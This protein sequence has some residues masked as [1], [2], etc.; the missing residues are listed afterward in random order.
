MRFRRRPAT[1]VTL[2][3]ARELRGAPTPA[4][5]CA[6]Q[7]LR[8]RRTLG[9]K[10]RRQHAIGRFIVDFYCAELRLVLEIDGGIHD[11]PERA[12]Y[13]VARTVSLEA[14]GFRVMRIRNDQLTA[15]GLKNLLRD[16]A[17]RPPSTRSGEGDRG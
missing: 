13:D 16:L 9:L 4:E 12:A 10:F 7:L 17:S 15:D 3:R 11:D 8:G 5:R 2:E 6:W 1:D 14:H